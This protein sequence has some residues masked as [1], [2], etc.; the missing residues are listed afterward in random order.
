M[1]I[2]TTV[3]ASKPKT[4]VMA[5]KGLVTEVRDRDTWTGDSQTG[6][7]TQVYAVGTHGLG[8]CTH[9]RGLLEKAGPHLIPKPLTGRLM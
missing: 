7:T 4:L 3:L 2:Y 8:V 9:Y 1:N 5:V 6:G